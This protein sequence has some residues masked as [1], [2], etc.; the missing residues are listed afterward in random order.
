MELAAH[1]VTAVLVEGAS[2]P[3]WGYVHPFSTQS[4]E[5][6]PVV[7][8]STSGSRGQAPPR[9][10]EGRLRSHHVPPGVVDLTIANQWRWKR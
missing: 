9:L 4:I 10:R 7:E 5:S 6:V 1:L 8:R 3:A 2:P